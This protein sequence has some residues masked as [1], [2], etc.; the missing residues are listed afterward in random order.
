[1]RHTLTISRAAVPVFFGAGA[2]VMRAAAF[3]V[4]TTFATLSHGADVSPAP[5]VGEFNF[6]I[7]G[8]QTTVQ[9]DDLWSGC[10]LTGG[11]VTPGATFV[12]NGGVRFAGGYGSGDW[13]C[14]GTLNSAG[15]DP[16]PWVVTP[17]FSCPI[18]RHGTGGEPPAYASQA[19]YW[20][21][22]GAIPTISC[23]CA[24]GR[25]WDSK[26]RWCMPPPPPPKIVVGFFNGVWNTQHQAKDGL[27]AL[28]LLIGPTYKDIPIRYEEF[29]NQTGSGNGN[30][31]LQDIAEVFIQRGGE[32][33][34]VLS[35]RWEHFWDVLAGRHADPESSSGNLLTSLGNGASALAQ[36]L[37]ATFSDVLGKIGTGVAWGRGRPPP[38]AEYQFALVA[39]SQGNLFV[40]AAFDSLKAARPETHAGVV[41]VAPASPTKRGE[42]LLADI[43]LVINGLR[44]QG[45]TSVQPININLPFSKAD[46][47]GHT[48][49]GTYLD[50]AREARERVHSMVRSVMDSL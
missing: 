50:P 8:K 3:V 49:V 22:Q 5:G 39:H 32:L 18:E 40:N 12:P 19:L 46:A 9:L 37:D 1:M 24:Y 21:T 17:K 36:L 44:V 30:T 13:G 28:G 6:Y 15:S 14:D 45:I 35:N 27:E 47:S 43:D 10:P 11:E 33:D 16:T 31:M 23:M 34:G 2:G 48:L 20:V 26:V 25:V 7:G 4:T 42:H 38:H 29:Y 41:H